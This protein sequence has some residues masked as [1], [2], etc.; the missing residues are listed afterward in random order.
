MNKKV[1]FYIIGLLIL[2]IIFFFVFTQGS[3]EIS[4]KNNLEI[5]DAVDASVNE[6]LSNGSENQTKNLYDAVDASVEQFLKK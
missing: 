5:Y 2:G 6:F 1:Y 3:K 4:D